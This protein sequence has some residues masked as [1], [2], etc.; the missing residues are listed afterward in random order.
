MNQEL[1]QGHLSLES[2][3]KAIDKIETETFSRN[4]KM[5]EKINQIFLNA[6]EKRLFVAVG[7][8]HL[9]Y[10]DGIMDLLTQKGWGITQ[11]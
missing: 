11:I 7:A 3:K 1:G 4:F 8:A 10:Q 5:T 6:P 9:P 2:V